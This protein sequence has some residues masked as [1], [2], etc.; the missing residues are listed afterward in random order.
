[1][2]QEQTLA[3]L[4]A[5]G[6]AFYTVDAEWRLTYVN[7]RIEQLWGRPR[8][9]LIGRRLGEILPQYVGTP[10][11]HHLAAAMKER[12][13][14]T[15]EA[16]SHV[17]G[18]WIEINCYPHGDGLLV[19]SHNLASRKRVEQSLRESEDPLRLAVAA[20]GLG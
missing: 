16:L 19:Y 7:R 4:E 1:V 13:A 11:H 12:R 8:E 10:A 6:D 17:T 15:F 9:A 3:I 18:S 20:T 5:I 14:T 2:A